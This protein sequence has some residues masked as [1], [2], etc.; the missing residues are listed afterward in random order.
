MAL[1]RKLK[2]LN[3]FNDS[4]SYQGVVTAVTLPK[5]SR[6]LDAYRGGGMNGAAFVD[7]GLDDDALDME[8]TIG[9]VDDLVLKQ[10]GSSAAVPLRFTGSYQRDDTGEEIAVE[11]EVRGRHQAFDFGEAKQGEDTETKIT[12]K[13][14]YFRLTWDGKEL[15]EIDTINM[16]EKVDGTDLLE[17]RR[18]NLGLM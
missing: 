15:M 3:L 14:T 16:I 1:P 18:K 9:G 11:I 13:N 17:Q 5:L 2:G 4:N 7:N 10:W 8:W 12:T 6:K